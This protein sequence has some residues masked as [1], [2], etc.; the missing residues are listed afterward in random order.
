MAGSSVITPKRRGEVAMLGRRWPAHRERLWPG[1]V[2]IK[3]RNGQD[4]EQ[5]TAEVRS[6][7]LL[8]NPTLSPSSLSL[9]ISPTLSL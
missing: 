6:F 3:N 8:V 1:L 2:S 7:P 9:S 5:P 4:R